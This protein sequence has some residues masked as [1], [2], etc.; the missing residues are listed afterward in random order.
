M[1]S[2]KITLLLSLFMTVGM[3]AQDKEAEAPKSDTEDAAALAKKLAN[4]IAN[5]ISVPFQNNT[6]FGIGSLNGTRNTL[7]FQPVIPLKLSEN[8]NLINRVIVPYVSQYN[9]TA[10]GSSQTGIGNTTISSWVSPTKVKNGIIW[11]AGPA[12][13]LPTNN[14]YIGTDK[15]G[16]GPT[17]IVLKQANGL[18]YGMLAN[19]LWS[20]IGP[21]AS[22]DVSQMFLQFFL[23]YNWKSGAG[24]GIS[25]EN[26]FNWAGNSNTS[27]LIPN[28]NAVTKLGKQIVQ[29]QIG[30]RIPTIFSNSESKPD[31]GVRA[32]FVLVFPK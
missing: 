21:S 27:Y 17:V 1:K 6:D 7:N 13:L 32:S 31:F 23:V 19:Q 16:V 8:L 18:T 14:E 15:T 20:V 22:A 29:V 24:L 10:P 5:L 28:V 30:P 12:F 2:I 25:S 11:G 26:T 9:V 3:F 4:P